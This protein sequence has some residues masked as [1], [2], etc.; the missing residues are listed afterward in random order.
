M[1]GD[2]VSNVENLNR[3][4]SEIYKFTKDDAFLK[5]NSM[6]E[7]MRAALNFVRFH[8][9]NVNMHGFF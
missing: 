9:E 4:K 8:Y 7:L 1:Q 2:K 5:S 6:G 3:L